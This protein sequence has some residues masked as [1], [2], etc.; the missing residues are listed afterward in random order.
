MGL[1]AD[2][3]PPGMFG[4]VD[5]IPHFLS[6]RAA[7]APPGAVRDDFELVWCSGWEERADEHLPRLLGRP[8]AACRT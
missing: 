6:A 8:A 2:I 1:P 7:D 5:G 4:D 3:R